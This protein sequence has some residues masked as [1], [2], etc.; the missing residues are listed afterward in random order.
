M[1]RARAGDAIFNGATAAAAAALY[2]VESNKFIDRPIHTHTRA[3]TSIFA[4]EKGE[5]DEVEECA[6]GDCWIRLLE[7]RGPC[8]WVLYGT[9]EVRIDLF[10]DGSLLVLGMMEAHG[11]RI[12]WP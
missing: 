10:D 1:S 3:T 12:I 7:L 9:G 2:I 5:R 6:P 8:G 11:R 4:G